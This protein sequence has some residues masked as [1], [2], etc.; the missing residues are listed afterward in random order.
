[1]RILER[2]PNLRLAD[3]EIHHHDILAARALHELR[4]DY[5]A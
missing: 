1:M 5:D 2:L 4:V 3:E